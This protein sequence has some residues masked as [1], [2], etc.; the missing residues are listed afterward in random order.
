MMNFFGY[1]LFVHCSNPTSLLGNYPG[2]L[3]S[4]RSYDDEQPYS[5]VGRYG[6][7][8]SVKDQDLFSQIYG[9][10]DQGVRAKEYDHGRHTGSRDNLE[11]AYERELQLYRDDRDKSRDRSDDPYYRNELLSPGVRSLDVGELFRDERSLGRSESRQGSRSLLGNA[12]HHE[13][14]G[15]RSEYRR[16]DERDERHMRDSQGRTDDHLSRLEEDSSRRQSSSSS[17]AKADPVSLL[18]NLSQLLA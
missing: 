4:S 10:R 7:M 8:E 15:G 9:D 5:K 11:A 18:L 6:G 12:P 1:M 13:D 17:S 2:D 14:E 3:G 16:Y